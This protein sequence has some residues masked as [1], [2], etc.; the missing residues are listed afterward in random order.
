MPDTSYTDTNVQVGSSYYYVVGAFDS[1]GVI[2][3]KAGSQPVIA[4]ATAAPS[5]VAAGTTGST[6]GGDRG[7]ATPTATLAAPLKVDAIDQ[8][9]YPFNVVFFG[10]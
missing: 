7:A 3:L 9:T 2:S 8:E 10:F 4:T 1:S 5:L 6:G